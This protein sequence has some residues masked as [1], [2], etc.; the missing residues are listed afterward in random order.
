[1]NE[2]INLPRLITLLSRQAECD[3]AVA[4]RYLHHFFSTIEAELMRGESVTIDGIGCFVPTDDTAHPVKF[5]ADPELAAIAN[6]PFSAFEAIEL[7]DDVTEDELN[8][9]EAT[10]QEVHEQAAQSEQPEPA[11]PE[12]PEAPKQTESSEHSE[13]SDES[14]MSDRSDMS[15]TSET[16]ETIETTEATEEV[17]EDNNEEVAVEEDSNA[18]ESAKEGSNDDDNLQIVEPEADATEVASEENVSE[19]E[20]YTTHH[21]FSWLA[22]ILGLLIGLV[23]GAVG[24]YFYGKSMAGYEMQ[25]EQFESYAQPTDSTSTT[26][27]TEYRPIVV[28]ADTMATVEAPTNQPEATAEKPQRQAKQPVYDTVTKSRFLTTMA[29][30]HY[31][32]KMYWVFIYEANPSL[33]NPNM[34][35][36]GTRILIPDMSTF[37]ESTE[38]K[39]REKAQAH[40]NTL[41]RKYKL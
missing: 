23:I 37:A 18:K 27:T 1:M 22:L 19:D 16:A 10:E 35:S 33:G 32:N 25:L 3:P 41:S 2:S 30:E 39:T 38:A 26:D 13:T 34:I 29:G 17:V 7:A 11:L 24:G 20:V 12:Q 40:L 6:E 21:G 14:D 15:D 31:G 5:L 9:A 28:A 8:E 4:R 36:P